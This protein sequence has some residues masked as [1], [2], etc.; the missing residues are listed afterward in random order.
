MHSHSNNNENI[1]YIMMELGTDA[2]RDMLDTPLFDLCY[3]TLFYPKLCF[4]CCSAWL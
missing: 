2:I 4:T 1:N 3:L